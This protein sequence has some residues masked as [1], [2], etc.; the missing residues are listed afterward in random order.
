MVKKANNEPMRPSMRPTGKAADNEMRPVK[1]RVGGLFW[2]TLITI[3][4]SIVAVM[5]GAYAV[6][7]RVL[8]VAVVEGGER[9]ASAYG[10][11]YAGFYNQIFS[12]AS[13]QLA[14]I[15]TVG[16][17]AGA[18]AD[19]DA[20][21]LRET[22]A[23][24]A[25][26]LADNPEVFLIPNQQSIENIPLG[27]A[28]QSMVERVRRGEELRAEVIPFKQRPLLLLAR[29]IRNDGD[30]VVG[31]LLIGFDLNEIGA[32]LKVFDGHTGYMLLQQKLVDAPE[33]MD[34]MQYGDAQHYASPYR[35]ITETIHP[36]LSV[37]FWLNP[38]IVASQALGLFWIFVAGMAL[39]VI[40]AIVG[41][42]VL[43]RRT[44]ERDASILLQQAES[45]IRRETVPIGAHFTT[46][47]FDE[48]SRSLKRTAST[49]AT[50]VT[51]R[52]AVAPTQRHDRKESFDADTD[53]ENDDATL[54]S[55]GVTGQT[56]AT[57]VADEIFRAYDIRGI[58]GKTLTESTVRLIGRAIGSEVLDAN[59]SAVYVGRDGRLSG[60]QL[61]GVLIDG[62][63]STGC[64]VINLGMVPTPLVY[65]ATTNTDIKSGVC[66]TGSH[67]PADY[68]G[69]KIVVNG[70][71]LSDQRIQ[72]LK[73]RILRNDFRSGKGSAETLDIGDRYIARIKDDVVL[74]RPMT[75]VVDCGNGVAGAI[76]PKLLTAI[77]CN[78]VPLF[79]D[80]DGHFPNHHPDPGNPD[81]LRDLMS[82]VAATK[83][84][85]GIAF[86]GDGD[87]LGVV[88]PKGQIIWPDRLMMLYA[89]D[90]LMRNP[91]ADIIY[92]VKCTRDLAA[93]ISQYGGRPMMWRTGHS[94]IKAKLRETGAAL[95]GEMSGH[96]F[97]NE[98]WFGFDDAMYAAARLLEILSLEATAADAV[99][100]AFPANIT[101]P[102]LHIKVSEEN[103]F[104]IIEALQKQGDF[105]GGS[106][107]MLDGVRVDYPASWGLVRASNTTPV[108]AARFEGK[109]EAD[110]DQVRAVFRE[111]LLKVEP[112][113]QI[114]F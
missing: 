67:N 92:D 26:L 114:P 44:L 58:V 78:V 37:V 74:A 36:N 14:S 57:A 70:E 55:H 98:R 66:L 68:N 73:Q 20:S 22:T 18:L 15:T 46:S 1:Q 48:I 101:T 11:Q 34:V 49:T 52:V 31:V 9:L 13:R 90:L 99:F 25:A 97:F 4:G 106:T 89:K 96:I 51:P 7:V 107:T 30:E 33:V 85:L 84:D 88:T 110:L 19:G 103:K 79:C 105:S 21:R 41:T 63:I 29:G 50:A 42:S 61:L 111:Q 16:G 2:F 12:Q 56:P 53:I 112:S 82:M 94:L 47:F 91:G 77:G 69:L 38:Q 39:L 24:I 43:L 8:D 10:Q 59:Q 81:N 109:T 108:L 32:N 113:L 72:A 6:K 27:Y 83:A 102:E 54:F 87:R 5:L 45:M 65:F 104:R 40:A 35:T 93:V 23:T 28:A 86:D 80:V 100:A 60:P 3:M 75:V 64:N 71:T 76:A 62:I 95:A 17:L